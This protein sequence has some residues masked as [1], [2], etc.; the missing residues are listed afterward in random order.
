MSRILITG[1]AGFI[2]ANLARRLIADGCEVIVV[3]DL[4]TGRLSNLNALDVEF[5]EGSILDRD[6]LRR[7][8]RRV[9]AIVHLAAIPSVPRSV[10]DPRP[11]HEVNA[12]GT[13]NVLELARD[14]MAHVSVASSS[15]VYGANQELPKA[16]SMVPRPRS[17]YAVSKLTAESYSIAWQMTYGLP[18]IAFRFFN[19]YGPLQAAGHA[20][21]AVIP[22]F[23]DAALKRMP[24]QVHGDGTQTRD[25]TFVDSVTEILA[26]AAHGRTRSDTPVNL[27]FGSRRSLLQVIEEMEE[28]LSLGLAVEFTEARVGDVRDSQADTSRLLSLFPHARETPFSEGL[29]RTM[30]WARN[31]MRGSDQQG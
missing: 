4:S 25:F 20:Y 5:V 14:L 26:L 7:A 19:V 21:A 27:A 13:L 28:I 18:T 6:L 8:G 3:D 11:S 10:A 1:G 30:A 29:G 12:T 16:E 15:S 23:M 9:T 2:G 22:A 31:H 24:L 17:P